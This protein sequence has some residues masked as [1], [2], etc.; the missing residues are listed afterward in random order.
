MHFSTTPVHPPKLVLTFGARP[1]WH[2]LAYYFRGPGGTGAASPTEALKVT[3]QYALLSLVYM[4]SFVILFDRVRYK[5]KLG[6]WLRGGNLM[7]R[8]ELDRIQAIWSACQ[9]N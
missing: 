1:H 2:S 7:S 5:H 6:G 9:D 8:Q 4:M 3:H